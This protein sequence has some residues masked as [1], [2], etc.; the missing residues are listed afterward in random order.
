MPCYLLTYLSLG[1]TEDDCLC[2]C[3]C[4]VQ[5]TQ[6]IKLPFFSLNCHKELFNPLQSQLITGQ[7]M[8]KITFELICSLFKVVYPLFQLKG[9][10]EELQ[11]S[12]SEDNGMDSV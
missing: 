5:V 6:S 4:V 3:Q 9:L 12:N 10:P 11:Q 2:D 1:I 8:K 7:K